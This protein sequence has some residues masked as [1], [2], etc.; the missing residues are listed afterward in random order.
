MIPF[1]NTYQNKKVLVT[2]HTGFKGSWLSLWLEQ[3]G[4]EVYG[5]SDVVPTVPSHFETAQLEEILNHRFLDV[6]DAEGI[7]ATIEE[8]RPDFIF[9]LA[10]QPLVKKSYE[11]PLETFEVNIMGTGT[12]LDAIRTVDFPCT[13]VFI[14]SDKCYDNGEW[15]YGY[16][17]TDALG[18][19]DP[20]SGSKGG[21]EL[22][23]KSYFHSYFVN[24][25]DRLRVGIGR[26]G[27]VIGGA[28]WAA[29]RIV[30]DCIRSWSKGESV[31]IRSPHATRPWQHVLEP[32]SGYLLLGQRLHE[33]LVGSAP[34]G[35]S[36]NGE[37]Y[38]FGP[39]AVQNINVGELIESML[40]HWEGCRWDDVSGNENG[41]HEAGLLKLCCDKALHGLRWKACLNYD[42]MVKY[43]VDWYRDFYAQPNQST[44]ALTQKQIQG[45]M[46]A[47]LKSGLSWISE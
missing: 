19:K 8:I 25:T 3:M 11:S 27:N 18:G 46:E 45:Y 24:Q 4:A 47:A 34:A 22:I 36:V 10:A 1:K 32:L 28:D 38:N 31:Q 13:V 9:H 15:T 21:A 5:I 37:A 43:T 40:P 20:Y 16:R 42:E 7:K 41:G 44:R 6:R 33:E 23:I 17:E 12:V 35:K 2:G 26:A 39:D 14:T 30:P 29:D